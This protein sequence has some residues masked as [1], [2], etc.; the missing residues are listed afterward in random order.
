MKTLYPP[1]QKAAEHFLG[2]L[3][4]GRH[5]LDTSEVGTGKTVVAA[6]LAKQLG[7]RVAII[8]PKAVITMW[9]REMIEMGVE[10]DCVMN[11]E[12]IRTGKTAFLSKKGKKI[13]TWLFEEPTFVIF[14]EVHKCKGPWTQNAQLLISLVQQAKEGGHLIHAMSATAAEDPTEMRSLGFMLGLHKL[15]KRPNSWHNWMNR[16]GCSV[17]NWGKWKLLSRKKLKAV[18]CTMYGEEGAAY[19]LTIND[20]PDSFKENRVFI[21]ALEFKDSKKILEAYDDYGVTPDIVE[22]YLEKGSVT[23]HEFDIVNIL[24]A[25]QLAESLKVPDIVEMTGDLIDQGK[26]VVIFVNF[27]DTAQALTEQLD[28]LSII[29]GQNQYQRQAQID[30]FMLDE[31]RI[32]VVNIAA[33][34]TGLSLHDTQGLYPRVSLISPTFSAKDHLQAL[35]RIHRNGAKSHALQKILVAAGSVEETVVKSITAKLENLNTLHTGSNA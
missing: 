1:Q 29:G 7:M 9:D 2:C 28:C 18:H 33:G 25:R 14:D 17:D 6:Y 34:G 35:G 12:R 21:E 20:F 13:M 27:K 15:N 11:Y 24:R 23:E 8:C 32:I 10:P 4:Q 26:S 19:R 5:T 30:D 16:N 3:K 31:K 22:Q